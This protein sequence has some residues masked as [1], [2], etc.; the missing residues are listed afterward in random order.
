[1]LPPLMPS[2]ARALRMWWRLGSK[3]DWDGLGLLAELDDIADPE[4]LIDDLIT[5][6]NLTNAERLALDD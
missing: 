6:R 1:M 5:I 4:A 3:L 2:G